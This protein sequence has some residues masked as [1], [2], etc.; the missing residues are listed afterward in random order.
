MTL[1]LFLEILNFAP[2]KGFLFSE[3]NFLMIT[4]AKGLLKNSSVYVL[5]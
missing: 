2:I 4:E 1:P 5:P 3:S